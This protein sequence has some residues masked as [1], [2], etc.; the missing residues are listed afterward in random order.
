MKLA[1]V[2]GND[3][4]AQP[5]LKKNAAIAVMPWSPNADSTACGIGLT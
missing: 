5:S 1:D 4:E 3:R 2:E